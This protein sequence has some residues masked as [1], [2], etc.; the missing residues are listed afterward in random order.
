[1]TDSAQ[2][3]ADELGG[4]LTSTDQHG[5]VSW[6]DWDSQRA[7]A[8]LREAQAEALESAAKFF[9]SLALKARRAPGPDLFQRH[10][11]SQERE[12]AANVL[13]VRAAELRGSEP[14]PVREG[15]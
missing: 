15:E 2:R 10:Y 6:I 5:D 8:L 1:V 14:P 7:A 11:R 12:Y 13:R 4:C 9:D 3:L